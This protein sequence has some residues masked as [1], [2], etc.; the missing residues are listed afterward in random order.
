[1][2][3]PKKAAAKKKTTA[4]KKAAPKTPTK[5]SKKFIDFLASWEGERLTAYQVPG[6][7]FYTIGVGHTGPVKGKKITA[8]TK[9]TQAESR[10]LLKKDLARFEKAVVRLVPLEWRRE[11]KHFEAMV[12][13]AFNMGEEILTASPPLTSFALILKKKHNLAN[14]RAA[15]A[16]ILLYTKGGQ[17]LRPMPGLVRRRQAE[18]KLFLTGEYD[19]N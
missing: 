8:R 12:S 14:V 3:A 16:A 4:K 1:M 9:I 11:R 13:L 5:V 7:N 17:P 6:E 15:A 19:H 2:P 18:R 10:E